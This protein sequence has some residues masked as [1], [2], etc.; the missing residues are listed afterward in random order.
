MLY[1][2]IGVVF[3]VGLGAALLIYVFSDDDG[4]DA[5]RELTHAKMYRHDVELIGGKGALYMARFSEWFGDLWHGRSLAYTVA[6][7]AAA[8]AGA[9]FVFALLLSEPTPLAPASHPPMTNEPMT[10]RVRGMLKAADM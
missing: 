9:C 4:V 2:V 6:V 7:I 8:I 1:R 3:A 5:S 10:A